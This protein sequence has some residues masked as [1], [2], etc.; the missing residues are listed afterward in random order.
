MVDKFKG[1]QKQRL[2]ESAVAGFN[3]AKTIT[4]TMHC[5]KAILKSKETVC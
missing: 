3:H 1:L 2:I 5:W 4:N